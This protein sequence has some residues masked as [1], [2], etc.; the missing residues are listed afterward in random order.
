MCYTIANLG[1]NNLY[2]NTLIPNKPRQALEK[3][4]ITL[5]KSI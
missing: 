4:L 3:M 1:C 5:G 2:F